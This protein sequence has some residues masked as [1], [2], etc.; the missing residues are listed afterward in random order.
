M[1]AL[2]RGDLRFP[3]QRMLIPSRAP[4]SGEP[5]HF[6][7]AP[8]LILSHWGLGFHYM[9]LRDTNIYSRAST[10][11]KSLG[12]A[13]FKNMMM[14]PETHLA[15]APISSP[16]APIEVIAFL[17]T[18]PRK[19]VFVPSLW[20]KSWGLCR[21]SFAT[22]AHPGLIIVTRWTEL[23]GWLKLI[24]VLCSWGKSRV[25]ICGTTLCPRPQLGAFRRCWENSH[26]FIVVAL[27]FKLFPWQTLVSQVF[28]STRDTRIENA[29]TALRELA[30]VSAPVGRLHLIKVLPC[31]VGPWGRPGFKLT[32]SLSLFFSYRGKT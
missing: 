9:N 31:C 27:P 11:W 25:G 4:P 16:S 32:Q 5:D 13:W 24:R 3:F 7:R 29:G 2:Q 20:P 10:E 21:S 23:A 19:N 6:S 15:K 14:S 28:E 1:C 12:K 17:L 8:P 18:A 30:E 22:C 26:M